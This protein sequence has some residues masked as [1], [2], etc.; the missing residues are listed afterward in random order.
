MQR[1][2]SE[3]GDKR[4][5]VERLGLCLRDAQ[6]ANLTGRSQGICLRIA[7]LLHEL[8]DEDGAERYLERREYWGS[9]NIDPADA[10]SRSHLLGQVAMSK[11][12]LE[13]AR[14]HLAQ[15]IEIAGKVGDTS[16]LLRSHA[17]LAEIDWRHGDEALRAKAIDRIRNVLSEHP[18]DPALRNERA[19]L[20]YELGAATVVAGASRESTETLRAGFEM[21]ESD[22]WRM[23][24]ANAMS[25]A[26][27]YLGD[28]AGELEWLDQAWRYAESSR[29]DSFKAR[30]LS[31]RGSW[32]FHQGQFAEAADQNRL[33]ATWARRFGSAFEYTAGCAGSAM[34]EIH[35]ARYEDA[36]VDAREVTRAAKALNDYTYVAKAFEIEGL[37]DYF[38]GRGDVARRVCGRRKNL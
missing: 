12:S 26:F 30:I 29:S 6:E 35:L 16:L 36:L 38:L 1:A 21:A 19:A 2:S 4:L 17:D 23:R 33:S 20:M 28:P 15:S 22:Y 34:C 7:A 3:L 31:N 9:D 18:Y 14:K 37:A 5:A 8:G 24:L 27:H 10:A 13:A 11:G 25:S 32:L